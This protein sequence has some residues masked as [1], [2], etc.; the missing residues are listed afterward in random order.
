MG[1]VRLRV[2]RSAPGPPMWLPVPELEE[3]EGW[4]SS[5]TTTLLDSDAAIAA[6]HVT[7]QPPIASNISHIPPQTQTY[8][9]Y[10]EMACE[11]GS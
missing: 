11:T 1:V 9:T 2:T 6:P 10:P 3:D 8:K 7:T 4:L 5:S